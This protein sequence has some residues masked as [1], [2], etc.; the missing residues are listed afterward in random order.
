MKKALFFVFAFAALGARAEIKINPDE[1]TLWSLESASK[2]GWYQNTLSRGIRPNPNGGFFIGDDNPVNNGHVARHKVPVS[3]EYPW[4]VWD[5]KEVYTFNSGRYQRWNLSIQN[6]NGGIGS[7]T[8]VEK[9]LAAVNCFENG[10]PLKPGAKEGILRAYFFNMEIG[11]TAIRMVKKPDNYIETTSPAFAKK[12]SFS[13][14]DE[15][16]F[17]VHLKEP[18]EDVTLKVIDVNDLYDIAVNGKNVLELTPEDEEQKIW[19]VTVKIKS[20]QCGSRKIGTLL[21]RATVLGGGFKVPLW[22]AVNYPYKEN[23]K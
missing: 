11:F 8:N 22:G 20:L 10:K 5:M 19:S 15:V 9:G 2:K 4:L 21:T 17:T 1:N 3:K 7:V 6:L 12:K 13:P 14:G 16:K 18:A 23:N